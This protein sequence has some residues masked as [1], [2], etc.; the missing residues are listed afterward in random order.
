MGCCRNYTDAP[1]ISPC[2]SA[3]ITAVL[4]FDA[5]KSIPVG[6][7]AEPVPKSDDISCFS[8]NGYSTDVSTAVF[9]AVSNVHNL[10]TSCGGSENTKP[11]LKHVCSLFDPFI[12]L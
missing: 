7:F 12:Y 6:A 10:N 11:E 3:I 4:K 8:K 2:K 1:E 5:E 9:C